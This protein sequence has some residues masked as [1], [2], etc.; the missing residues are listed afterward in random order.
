[1]RLLLNVI[2]FS[3]SGTNLLGS[4]RDNLIG[5]V[6]N[7]EPTTN[8]LLK[9]NPEYTCLLQ[10]S[11]VVSRQ[12][13]LLR[14]GAAP[15]AGPFQLDVALLLGNDPYCLSRQPADCRR[16][17]RSRRKAGV[18]VAAGRHKELPGARAH[19]QH[20]VGDRGRYPAQPRH[21]A[22]LLG[23][24]T[25]RS[26]A[27]SPKPPSIRQCI[28]GPAIAGPEPRE[29]RRTARRCTARAAVPLWPG[30][31]PAAAAE[32]AAPPP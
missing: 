23:R 3:N 12:R 20:R 19:H 21:R 26:P 4:S 10:G 30:V 28:P 17:G 1:M 18:R 13:R 27:P 11:Q 7:L 16:Q 2:G 14:R 22:S 32:P 25:S 8:L 6:N 24:T 29:R 9:Y 31:P 5:S 15:T